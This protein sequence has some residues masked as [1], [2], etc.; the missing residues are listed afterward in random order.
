M[1]WKLAGGIHEVMINPKRM[2]AMNPGNSVLTT[3]TFKLENCVFPQQPESRHMTEWFGGELVT[4]KHFWKVQ[5]TMGAQLTNE[6]VIQAGLDSK[7]ALLKVVL[8]PFMPGG[9]KKVMSVKLR[10]LAIPGDLESAK[11]AAEKWKVKV[12]DPA[13]MP[14]LAALSDNHRY[15]V[16]PVAVD[17]KEGDGASLGVLPIVEV[18]TLDQ[19]FNYPT[20]KEVALEMAAFFRDWQLANVVSHHTKD[21]MET[22]YKA[23]ARHE[24]EII[25]KPAAV[26]PALV[27]LGESSESGKI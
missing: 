21:S 9:R 16:I 3:F 24:G 25:C 8:E 22:I 18:R 17:E 20:R 10:V 27:Q 11:A 14:A 1:R 26:W 23:P 2:W 6:E 12:Q 19:N 4:I 7:K 15:T 5:D 13:V